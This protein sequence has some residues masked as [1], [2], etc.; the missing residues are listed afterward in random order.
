MFLSA[1]DVEIVNNELDCEHFQKLMLSPILG[2]AFRKMLKEIRRRF[3]YNDYSMV[4]P[5]IGFLP[6]DLSMMLGYLYKRSIRKNL[7]DHI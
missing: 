1:K 3:K 7:S 5:E 6:T 4:D 2:E